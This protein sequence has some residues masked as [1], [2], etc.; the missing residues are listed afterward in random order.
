MEQNSDARLNPSLWAACH[1]DV[2]LG[3]HDEFAY[4]QET[5]KSLNG[6]VHRCLKELYVE[7]R[8]SNRCEVEVEQV[9]RE[10]ASIDYR[11]DPLLADACLKE[12]RMLCSTESNDKKEDC[13]RLAFQHGKIN[14]EA[15]C[16]EVPNSSLFSFIPRKNEILLIRKYV[17]SSWK[18]QLI[19]SPTMSCRRYARM[20]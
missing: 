20:I 17:E 4:A 8:L 7:N 15:K 14:R 19:F 10:A 2:K 9:M 1:N 18:V 11:L 6:R 13:L 12:I 5:S 3:C 16:F